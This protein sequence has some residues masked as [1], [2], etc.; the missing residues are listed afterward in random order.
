MAGV[1][2]IDI[3]APGATIQD[4][5]RFGLLRFGVTAAGP[6]DWVAHETANRALGNEPDAAAIEIGPGGLAL[7]VSAAMP[8]AFAGGGFAWSR[9]EARLPAAARVMLRPGEILRARAGAWGSFAYC[10]VPGGIDVPPVMG[11]RATHTRSG[12][13]GLGRM[14]KPGDR[15][16][17]AG[18]AAAEM[19]DASIEAAWL[20]PGEAAL[21]VILGPQHDHFTADALASFVA[22]PFK[23]T[24]AADRM[25]YK[26]EGR[27][28]AHDRDFNIVSDGIAHGA[29]QV[30][31]DGQPMVLMADRQPTGGYAKIATVCR[32]DIGRLAQL[33]PGDTCRFAAI[34]VA[35]AREA[36]LAL[37]DRVAE[38]ARR[39]VPLR[40]EPTTDAL[41]AANLIGGVT[42]ALGD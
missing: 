9:G 20:A 39:L 32:A 13:G 15:L 42:D 10:A 37:E 8:V 18:D 2:T 5:G 38:T 1:V 19:P 16:A 25:A 4:G 23:L 24:A 30:A 21:R 40:R 22:A 27:R 7:G 29:I 33:R 41:I 17:V 36:L 6:M 35:A 14:L 26:L 31:G 28:I 3:A 34:E 11:S 12:L